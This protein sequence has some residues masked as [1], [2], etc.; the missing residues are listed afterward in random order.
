MS[1]S[2]SAEGGLQPLQE[3]PTRN[4]RRSAGGVSGRKEKTQLSDIVRTLSSQ[5]VDSRYRTEEADNGI[6][7]TRRGDESPCEPAHGPDGKKIISWEPD[8][9]ENPYNWSSV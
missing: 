6:Q 4:S 8:D 7:R 9:K 3:T 5:D 2:E 1:D